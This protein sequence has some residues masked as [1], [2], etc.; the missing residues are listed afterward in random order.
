MTIQFTPESDSQT[1]VTL[2]A[3]PYGTTDAQE[4]QTF[5]DTRASMTGGWTNSFDKLELELA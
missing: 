5:L 1:R 2:I 3:E 4:I